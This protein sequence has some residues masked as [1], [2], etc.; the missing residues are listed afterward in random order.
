MDGMMRVSVV[1]T[2]IDANQSYSEMPV[3]RRRLSTPLVAAEVVEEKIEKAPV[4]AAQARHEEPA[5]P[6]LDVF[7]P[8]RTARAEERQVESYRTDGFRAMD[9]DLPPPAYQPRQ[10]HAPQPSMYEPE[11]DAFVA[12]RAPSAG[13]PSPEALARLQAAVAKQPR[14]DVR[15]EHRPEPQH[16]ADAGAKGGRFGINS[17]IGRMT[18]HA[19]EAEARPAAPQPQ[20]QPQARFGAQPQV[21]PQVHHAYDED[22]DPNPEAEK[23]E[24]PAFLR[25]QAN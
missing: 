16:A 11:P 19:G 9:E 4:P 18:G 12:P 20:A 7:D 14:G 1:A 6:T 10:Q 17:L 24:I 2:G 22:Q 23:I 21:R 15:A 5:Q 25:R 8:Q 3:A 13:T